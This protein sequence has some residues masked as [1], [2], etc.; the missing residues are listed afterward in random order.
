[1]KLSVFKEFMDG[2]RNSYL[3]AV[4]KHP[5]F[6]DKV[7]HCTV[8]DIRKF[9]KECR[10]ANDDG[11]VSFSSILEEEMAEYVEASL[12]GDKEQAKRELFDCAAVLMREWERINK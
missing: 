2:M 7:S 8:K 9:L 4:E 3:H 6:V 12:L 11:D 5:K 10:G 1:M